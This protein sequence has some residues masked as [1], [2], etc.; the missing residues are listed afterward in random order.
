MK[1]A[2]L[3]TRGIPNNYGGFEQFA[4]Y[5]G[6]GLVSR[7]HE[8][9]V[10]N[11]SNHIYN[12]SSYKGINLIFKYCPEDKIGAFANFYYDWICSYDAYKKDY[13]IVYHAGYQSAAPA[14]KYFSS[15]S[16]SVWITN[17]DGIEWKRDKWSK[18]VKLLT[19]IMEKIAIKYSDYLISDNIGIQEY[20][21]NTHK[22]KSFLLEYGANVPEKIDNK[23]LNK[24]N[25]V[26]YEYSLIIARLE[27][28][29]SVDV[30]LQGYSRSGTKNPILVIGNHNTRY[31]KILKLKF[32]EN[33]NIRFVGAIYAKKHL[34]GL[35]KFAK[36]YFHGHT[37]GGTNPSL[38]EAMAVGSNVV[39]HN[40]SF[41]KSVING[42]GVFFSNSDD[43][44]NIIL[45]ESK[46]N[47][48]E[49]RKAVKEIVKS[50]YCWDKIITQHITLFKKLKK[51]ENSNNNSK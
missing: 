35:R 27:P 24:Y 7:G 16:K 9:T 3:G 18:P 25:L 45:N 8:V 4:E 31:G 41:N 23:I 36:F 21:F 32:S 50:K 39:A 6:V 22:V 51:N 28:E 47:S 26:D 46:Y 29:N 48:N 37:V 19:K 15:K 14:I 49:N 11:S 34:D 44:E 5:L 30:I 2:I 12:K 1:I 13:D 10:Y 38:L 40:N 42:K 17:M 20:Y 33:K 43:V